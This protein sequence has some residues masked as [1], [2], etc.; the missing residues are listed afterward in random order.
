MKKWLAILLVCVMLL[1]AAACATAEAATTEGLPVEWDL[2]SI[3]ASVE[4]WQADY[5]E[6]MAMLD[7]YDDFRGTLNSAQSLSV[8]VLSKANAE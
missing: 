7:R 2:D 3:Y 8:S 5:D 6:V 4:E 1:A